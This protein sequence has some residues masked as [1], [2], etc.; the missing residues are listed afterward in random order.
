MNGSFCLWS[1]FIERETGGEA[2][3]GQSAA[4]QAAQGHHAGV[5]RGLCAEHHGQEAGHVR[6]L[7]S[8]PE[9][10]DEAHR[11]PQTSR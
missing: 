3:V 5:P 11:L 7:Q 4:G 8:G 10:Q 9:G 6:P 1:V 2:K